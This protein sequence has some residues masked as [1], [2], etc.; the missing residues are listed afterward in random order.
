VQFRPELRVLSEEQVYDIRQAALDILW[1]TGVLVKA[2]AARALLRQAGA[3]IDEQTMLCRIPGYI[4]E[5]ALNRAPSSFTLY[6]RNPAHNVH[7]S[8]RSLHYEPMIGRLRRGPRIARR[9]KKS[10]SWSS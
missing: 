7:V 8:T 5:E 3:W 1:N 6:A 10:N 9:W 2:P 4:I